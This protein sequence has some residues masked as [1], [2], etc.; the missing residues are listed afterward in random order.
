MTEM[1]FTTVMSTLP[2]Y[3][4]NFEVNQ[5]LLGAWYL[6]F[7]DIQ[8]EILKT[9][10]K[11]HVRS[12]QY[13]PNINDLTKLCEDATECMKNE[14]LTLMFRDGYFH[15]G[16]LSDVQA[17][18]NYEKANRWVERKVEPEWLKIDMR[19][20]YKMQLGNSDVKRLN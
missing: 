17:Q 20:Y 5:A 9:A 6:F 7:E 11:Q 10:I 4:K 18:R 15:R 16:D 19:A 14:T 2:Y 1:E 13:P 12:S 3:Y 8:L